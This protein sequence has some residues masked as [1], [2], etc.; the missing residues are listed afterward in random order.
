MDRNLC[1]RVLAQ[2]LRA[3]TNVTEEYL[4]QPASK[5]SELRTMS[6]GLLDVAGQCVRKNV[7][8]AGRRV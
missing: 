7:G 4:V 8:P 1:V 5:H 2:H 3:C 6:R